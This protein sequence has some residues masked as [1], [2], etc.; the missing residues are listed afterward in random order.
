MGLSSSTVSRTLTQAR[1]KQLQALQERDLSELDLVTVF[2]AG[3]TVADMTIVVAVGI[4][5]M[6]EKH[7]LGFVET[8]T[9]NEQVLTPF[10]RSLGERGLQSAQGASW[11][12]LMG[13]KAC[14]PRCGRGLARPPWCNA[15]SGTSEKTS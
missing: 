13:A 3:K 8:G 2:L 11:S 7:V 1:A 5:R 9:K 4:T 6:G 14:G 15:V 12:F 10:L